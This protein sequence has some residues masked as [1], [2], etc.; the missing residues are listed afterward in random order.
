MK[1]SRK[2][3]FLVRK[4]PDSIGGV[5]R[6]SAR[7]YEGLS[8]L[9]QI[10]RIS[11]KGPEWG[12]PLYFPL[13]YFKSVSNGAGLIHCDDAVTAL[14]GSRVRKNSDKKVVATVHGL[15]VVLPIPWYQRRL[16]AALPTL[17]K[18]ICVSN[19]TADRVRERGVPEGK[20]EVIS[21][22]AEN[23]KRPDSDKEKQ[24]SRFL[25]ETGI[26]LRGKRVL[27]SLGRP[28][29]RKGF[30]RFITDVFPSLPDDCV[31][32][33][34]GPSPKI[35]SSIRLLNSVLNEKYRRL[36]LT[37]SGCD[38]IHRE[39]NQLARRPRVH[40]LNFVSDELREIIF[41]LADLFIM[42][43]RCVEGDMEGF[44]IVALEAA[45]RG[46]PVIATAIEG[47]TDAVIDGYNGY[48]LPEND[49]SAMAA[50]IKSLL[51]KPSDLA[52]LGEKARRFTLERFSPSTIHGRYARIFEDLL[53]CS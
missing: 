7:L 16:R 4:N 52:A 1:K 13:F 31:Y 26:D 17:D 41:A 11:W 9:F 23:I 28:I 37:A 49:P 29:R 50:V 51:E 25:A 2:I 40:Y 45:V 5:Q 10:E 35:P 24:Y 30:D 3:V 14:V 19:A 34:A 32:V 6:H 48:C 38:T 46:V 33:I 44:G 47:V 15:D 20:I 8:D 36:F 42:P 12:A 21:N 18:V 53:D 22:A 39:L 27:F 43:N